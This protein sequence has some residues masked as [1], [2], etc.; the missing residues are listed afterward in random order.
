MRCYFNYYLYNN[1]HTGEKRLTAIPK[2]YAIEEDELAE[3]WH[4]VS[5]KY[6]IEIFGETDVITVRNLGDIIWNVLVNNKTRDEI[7]EALT[8]HNV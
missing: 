6:A 4:I 7:I 8:T 5:R 2:K 3:F 1:I